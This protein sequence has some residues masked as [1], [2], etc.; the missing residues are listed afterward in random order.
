MNT[1]ITGKVPHSQI[2]GSRCEGT[3]ALDAQHLLN[4]AIFL[5]QG[6]KSVDGE[7]S[8]EFFNEKLDI[9]LFMS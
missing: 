2:P 5:L 6:K 9:P 1:Q 7:T 3:M 8:R 4:I